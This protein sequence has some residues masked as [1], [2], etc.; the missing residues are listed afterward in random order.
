MSSSLL[1]N[2]TSRSV[3]IKVLNS[4]KRIESRQPCMYDRH[5][6][7]QEGLKMQLSMQYIYEIYRMGSFSRA[8]EKLYITQPALSIAV[9]KVEESIGMPLFDRSTRPVTLTPA[10]RIY[11]DAIE[12]TRNLEQDLQQQLEDIRSLQSGKIVIG[13]THYVNCY[14]LAPILNDFSERYP[15]IEIE[16]KEG[17]SQEM[18]RKLKSRE[19]DLTLNCDPESVEGFCAYPIFSDMVL[20]A[21]PE[22]NPVNRQYENCSL[23]AE[24][25]LAG[26]HLGKDCPSLP[27]RAFRDLDFILLK[28]GNNLY[29]RSMELFE[30]EEIE[31]HVKIKISQLVTAFHLADNGFA[32][33]FISDR[34]IRNESLHLL[35]YKI[36]SQ[37]IYRQFY[38]LLNNQRYI[39]NAVQVFIQ[40]LQD[41]L[42]ER[43]AGVG[44]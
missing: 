41:C 36:D 28:E 23:R 34:L 10:G 38:A 1:K 8:A 37:N 11:V 20:L 40:Y 27:L 9:A 3:K 35:I 42:G 19:I 44:S 6:H 4:R 39:S 24:D 5:T 16:L 12:R 22:Q 43:A 18:I 32:A 13:A 26:K 14:I 21:V 15:G 25:I 29:E 7:I 2:A 33:T 17:E 31:P 30:V